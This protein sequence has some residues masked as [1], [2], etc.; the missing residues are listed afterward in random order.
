MSQNSIEKTAFCPGPGYGLWEFTVMPYRLACTGTMQTCQC[1]L[2]KILK[3]CVD[4]YIDDC[5]VF[6]DD[7]QS[8]V[9]DLQDSLFVD[10]S[11]HLDR[12]QYFTWDSS[13]HLKE[14]PQLLIELNQSSTGQYLTQQISTAASS[15]CLQT[16]QLRSPTS[17]PA[18]PPSNGTMSNRQLSI[19]YN[20]P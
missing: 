13:T 3:D 17:L 2:D 6:S 10:P 7:M 9:R 16:L 8:H 1:G 4:N 15:Q 5:I 11:V 14:Y 20:E 12:R 19:N 18:K